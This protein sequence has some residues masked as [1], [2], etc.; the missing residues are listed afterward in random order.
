MKATTLFAFL[1]GLFLFSCSPQENLEETTTALATTEDCT[2]RSE[3]R[4]E[5]S[6]EGAQYLATEATP[7]TFTPAQMI[8]DTKRYWGETEERTF[9]LPFAVAQKLLLISEQKEIALHIQDMD[10]PDLVEA[11]WVSF[12]N[13]ARATAAP[14]ESFFVLDQV[15]ITSFAKAIMEQ[16]IPLE[17]QVLTVHLGRSVE[18]VTG[19]YFMLGETEV[20]LLSSLEDSRGN[21]AACG[22]K[23]PPKQ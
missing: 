9:S 2:N 7:T 14:C 18:G 6:S 22:A 17:Q 23:I 20:H 4:L 21:S 12:S 13:T 15:L 11:D 19:S 10:N 8:A 5:K 1:I 16:A 3:A